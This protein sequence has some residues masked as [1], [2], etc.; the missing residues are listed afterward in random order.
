MGGREVAWT[1]TSVGGRETFLVVVSPEPVPELEAGPAGFA[2]P[3][4]DRPIEYAAVDA[5]AVQ[6]LRGV[7]GLAAVAPP[8]KDVGPGSGA[9]T[10]FRALAGRESGVTG[11]WVREIVLRNPG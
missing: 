8:A 7:G 2:A 1:V 3:D 6:R 11:V 5:G 4:P 9:L 10:R